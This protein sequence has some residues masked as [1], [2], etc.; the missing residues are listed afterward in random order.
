MERNVD[1]I[2][3]GSGLGG[4]FSAGLLGRVGYR[5]LVLE[6]LDIVGGRYTTK[7]YEGFKV[8]TGSWALGIHGY[9]GPVIKTLQELGAR[10][11]IKVPGPPDRKTRLFG[12]DV[13]MPEKGGFRVIISMVA[14]N[15]KEEERVMQA[16]R[17][18]LFWQEPSDAMN[19]DEWVHSLT[20]NPLIHGMF[21]FVV[22]AMTALNYYEIPAGEAFRILRNFG[23]FK[24]VTTTV[25]DGNK[26]TVDALLEAMKQWPI[27]IMTNT[28]VEKI[29]VE[30]GAVK[31]V[32][33]SRPRGEILKATAKVILSNAGPKNTVLL[34]GREHFDAGTLREVDKVRPSAAM[35]LIF[36]YDKPILDYDGFINF[37][38]LPRIT[39]IWEPH[40]LWP[41]YAPKGK[42]C[43]YAYGTMKTPVV[44]REVQ[45]AIEEC[46]ANFPPLSKANVL[47]KL[48]FQGDWPIMRAAIGTGVAPKTTIE[49]LYNVGDGTNP[50]GWVCGEGVAESVHF[51]VDD[52]MKRYAL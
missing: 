41:T 19:L 34:A 29:V 40:H 14:K 4:L 50:S 47:T 43:M 31:G 30:D 23:R 7:D 35:T 27:E 3:I 28:R 48:V 37:I 45:L 51:V 38:D 6:S 9:Q 46:I 2:V 44:E 32:Q 52:L 21:D 49:G 24:G 16:T 17:R 10:P 15:K 11:E 22:R 8:N 5:V 39:T 12:K 42:Y 13:D 36:A 25:K 33:A 20:D 1:I 18:A 26:G